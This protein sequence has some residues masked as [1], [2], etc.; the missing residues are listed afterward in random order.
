MVTQSFTSFLMVSKILGGGA[1]LLWKTI[2]FRCFHIVQVVNMVRPSRWGW[3]EEYM[4]IHQ[5]VMDGRA[6]N[7]EMSMDVI[8]HTI[9]PLATIS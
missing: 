5:F 2:T 9:W 8:Q 3:V 1:E 4:G 7:P 6:S